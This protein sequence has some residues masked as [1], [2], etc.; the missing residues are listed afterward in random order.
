MTGGAQVANCFPPVTT[1]L[2]EAEALPERIQAL[3]CRRLYVRGT[4]A[5]GPAVAIVGARG[6]TQLG[7]DRAH[8]I[9]RHLAERGVH[10]VS[11]GALGIDGAA[12]RGALAGGGTTT[13]VLGCGCDVAYPSR[14]AALFDR[15]LRDG[16]ALVSKQRDG[17][18]PRR[19]SFLARNPLIAALADACVVVEADARSGSLATARAA[20]RLGRIVVAWPGSRG[21]ELLLASG[22]AMVEQPGDVDAA[23]AGEPRMPQRSLAPDDEIVRA[24]IETGA[25]SVEAIVTLTR[26]PVRA[27]LRALARMS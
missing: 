21:C 5:A 10:V 11:G 8:A 19:G 4:L 14:H 12:H 24:A 23:L 25:S 17:S 6:A 1:R 16:G 26:L 7:M 22:A 20:R 13:V 3:R 27:V 18:Q 15:V 9:G 2:V